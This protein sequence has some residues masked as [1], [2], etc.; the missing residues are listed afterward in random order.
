MQYNMLHKGQKSPFPEA[1]AGT[2]AVCCQ[3][4]NYET[5]S[6]R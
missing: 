1:P 3:D 5:K 6:E 4:V 2:V